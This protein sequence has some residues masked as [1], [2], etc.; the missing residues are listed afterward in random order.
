ML[1]S[2]AI[3]NVGIVVSVHHVVV[4][5][6]M[7]SIMSDVSMATTTASETAGRSPT[8]GVPAINTG[9]T[10]CT[11]W[12]T[13]P[14]DGTITLW[15]LVA[16]VITFPSVRCQLACRGALWHDLESVESPPSS[17]LFMNHVFTVRAGV[18][19]VVTALICHPRKHGCLAVL[20]VVLVVGLP[21]HS[22][23]LMIVHFVGTWQ[24]CKPMVTLLDVSGGG[25]TIPCNRWLVVRSVVHDQHQGP[26]ATITIGLPTVHLF[27]IGFVLFV[28]SNHPV[29]AVRCAFPA[30]PDSFAGETCRVFGFT[31]ATID[32]L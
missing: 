8:P 24:V 23:D 18:V 14:I 21:N 2:V 11:N 30:E 6:T 32:L 10:T 28:T 19:R 3:V 13:F 9:A 4:R 20:V 25:N 27:R 29:K 17:V 22:P 12:V 1:R 31:A 16:I 5:G 7:P 15:V 26:T